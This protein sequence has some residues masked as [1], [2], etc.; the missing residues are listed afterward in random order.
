MLAPSLVDKW[1]MNPN[2]KPLN[3]AEKRAMKVLN[4]LRLIAK[5]L[6][7]SSGYKQCRQNEI[8]ALIKKYSTPALFITLNPSDLTHLWVGLFGGISEG[9][10]S[11]M[12][13]HERAHYV[14]CNPGAATLFFDVMMTSSIDIILGYGLKEGGLFCSLLSVTM[15]WSKHRAGGL[16]T[17]TF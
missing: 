12:D 16:S 15:V 9:V 10:W 4:R 14:A 7:G 2:A 1:K 5:D 8:R 6:K 17:V 13:Q 3:K 11:L